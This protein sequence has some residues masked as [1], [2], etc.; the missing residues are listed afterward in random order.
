MNG[1]IIESRTILNS[2]IW[3]KPPLYFKVWHYLLLKAQHADYKDLKRGQLY[4]SIGEIREACSYY[5][6]YRKETPSRKEIWS[7]LEWL[8]NPYEGN[9]EGNTKGN[10]ERNM[11]VTTKAT[12]GILVTICNYNVY[13]DPKF[14]E[15]N[16]ER[17]TKGIRREQ[18]KQE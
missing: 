8:R 9:A 1:Y 3:K 14:Y 10:D 5:V 18:Y 12:H 11:I 2:E 15:G 16:D 7:I 6:G 4:T 13:Q 17:N